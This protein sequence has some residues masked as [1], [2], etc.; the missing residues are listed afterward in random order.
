MKNLAYGTQL[1]D[2]YLILV[3]GH[4]RRNL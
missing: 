4:I 2:V 3:E 1:I